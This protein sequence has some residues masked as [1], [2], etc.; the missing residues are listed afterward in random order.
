MMSY[1]KVRDVM[2]TDPVTVTPTTP[3]RYVADILV[4][5]KISAVPVLSV[6]GKLLGLV[7]E[8]DLLRKEELKRDPDSEQSRHMTYQERRAVATAVTAGEIM[9]TNPVTVRADATLAEAARLMDRY[10]AT[11]LPVVD[12][13]GNLVGVV[14]LWDLLRVFPGP[15]SIRAE[16][17]RETLVGGLGPVPR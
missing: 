3:L 12:E 11:C 15:D 8:S 17:T 5:Q 14:G 13:S 6:R 2:T 1:H 16:I 10:E 4:R 9:S 7:A